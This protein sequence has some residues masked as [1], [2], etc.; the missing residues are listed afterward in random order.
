[1]V[2]LYGPQLLKHYFLTQCHVNQ[3]YASLSLNLLF[4][5]SNLGVDTNLADLMKMI[6]TTL[7]CG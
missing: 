1:M 3:I 6:V 2:S 7:Q 4:I 5:S